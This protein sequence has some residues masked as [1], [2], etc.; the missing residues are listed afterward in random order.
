[1]GVF[2]E[3]ALM[4]EAGN[5]ARPIPTMEGIIV[6]TPV[7]KE[8]SFEEPDAE[9]YSRIEKKLLKERMNSVYASMMGSFRNRSKITVNPGFLE[10]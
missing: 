4:I 8:I 9:N 2:I 7:K 1:M 5:I 10:N 6:Y 3:D